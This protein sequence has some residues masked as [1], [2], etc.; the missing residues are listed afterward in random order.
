[1][2]P[3][4]GAA[5]RPRIYIDAGDAA[6]HTARA[7]SRQALAWSVTGTRACGLS[8]CSVMFG[9]EARH[10]LLRLAIPRRVYTQ[11][12]VDYLWKA[13]LEVNQPQG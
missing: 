7:I 10:E 8:N 3:D 1:M 12:H 4:C 5:R 6:A 9:A 2:G 13:I 11:S